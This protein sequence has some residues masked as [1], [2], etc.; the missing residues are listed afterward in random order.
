MSRFTAAAAFAA[1]TLAISPAPAQQKTGELIVIPAARAQFNAPGG[2]TRKEVDG[3]MRFVPSDN[4]GRLAYVTFSHPNESTRRIGQIATQF[5]L[6]ALDWGSPTE[7]TIGPDRFPARAASSRSCKL[8]NGDSCAVWYATVN[9]GGSTQLLVVYVVNTSRG[10][11]VLSH[12]RAS[13]GS[14]RR[15]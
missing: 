7:E 4:M 5:E 14:L 12:V 13:V 6:S 11:L 8:K 1:V 2:W 15:M 3:W 10:A 9:P